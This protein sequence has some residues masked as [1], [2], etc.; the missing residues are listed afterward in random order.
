MLNCKQVMAELAHYLDEQIPAETYQELQVH[1]SEC[2]TCRVL[3]DST[4]KTLRII[5]ESRSFELAGDVSGRIMAKIMDR[6][7]SKQPLEDPHL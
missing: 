3:Y 6:I 7:R 1:L 5:T 4:R 2:Q